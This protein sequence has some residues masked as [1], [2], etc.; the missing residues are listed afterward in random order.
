MK[1]EIIVGAALVVG[2]TAGLSGCASMQSARDRMVRRAP[3]C[4]D[5]TVPI[6]FESNAADVTPE[7]RKVL[8]AAARAVRRCKVESVRVVGLADA[9]G[10][11]AANLELSKKRADAVADA[12]AKA[13]LPAAQFDLVA[14]GDA[15][16]V[17]ARGDTVPVRRRADVTLH[18]AGRK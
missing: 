10:A 2:L 5:V 14:A 1:T 4:Q 15:G 3:V 9:A 8:T 18:L 7:G 13:G 11:Q 12:V 17:T 16:S 6:Y